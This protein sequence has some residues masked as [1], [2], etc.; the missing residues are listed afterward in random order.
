MKTI[1]GQRNAIRAG[2][3]AGWLFIIAW[4]MF[5]GL[6]VFAAV[7]QI[8]LPLHYINPIESIVNMVLYIGVMLGMRGFAVQRA[9]AELATAI[10]TYVVISVLLSTLI[11]LAG[12]DRIF[13]PDMIFVFV[14]ALIPLVS[15]IGIAQIRIA[16]HMKKYSD[17]LGGVVRRVVWWT[18][19][20]G[21]MMASVILCIPGLFLSFVADFF[22]WRFL[23]SQRATQGPVASD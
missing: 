20:S 2:W 23:A 15:V 8:E 7:R 21:W 10:T 19:V 18:R 4:C 9:D 13:S 5:F 14:I 11:F 3:I 1:F 16:E 17:E 6:G 12:L 22:W